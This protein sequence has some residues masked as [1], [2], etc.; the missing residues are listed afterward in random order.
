MTDL[1][2][3]PATGLRRHIPNALVVVRLVLAMG[4]FALLSYSSFGG[5]HFAW[6]TG[7]FVI[8]AITDALDGHLARRWNA[9]SIFGRVMDPFADKVLILGSIILLVRYP[10]FTPFMAAVIVIRELLVTSLRAVAESQ[11]QDFSAS[12]VGKAKMIVQSMCI[13]FMFIVLQI[14]LTSS[15]DGV[16]LEWVWLM[17]NVLNV[18]AWTTTIVT[19]WSA[20]PYI[21]NAWDALTGGRYKPNPTSAVERATHSAARALTVHGFGLMRPFPGTWGSLPPV[22]LAGLLFMGGFGQLDGGLSWQLAYYLPLAAVF[23]WA[24]WACIT[25]GH[26][27]EAIFNKKDP[28]PVVADEVA[29]QCIPLIALPIT[30]ETPWYIALAWL[31]GAFIAFRV[32]DIVKPSPAREMQHIRGGWGILLDDLVAGVYALATIQIIAGVIRLS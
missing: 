29:G 15:A 8:A 1:T 7:L 28:G 16:M 26:L 27:G 10:G 25:K 2:P 32:F 24:C 4:V 9:V 23:L 14:Y 6:A 22:I 3:A 21:F 11:G 12:S 18:L 31:A 5:W 30:F 20:I 17:L 13:P 19:I